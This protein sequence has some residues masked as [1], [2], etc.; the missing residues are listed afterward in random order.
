MKDG[1]GLYVTGELCLGIQKANDV[2]HMLKE[3][4]IDSMSIGYT[5][6]DF[7]HTQYFD[8]R[9]I[10]LIK[11]IKLWEISLVTFPANEG[12]KITHVKRNT[13]HPSDDEYES[14]ASESQD[15]ESIMKNLNEIIKALKNN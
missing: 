11:S 4:I 12:A 2:Y 1:R 13:Q 6:E 9:M 8:G 5:A 7:E 10:R 3:E 14:Y 15:D